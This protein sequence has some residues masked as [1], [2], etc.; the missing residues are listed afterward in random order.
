MREKL[1]R[2]DSAFLL[3]VGERKDFWESSSRES[4]GGKEDCEFFVLFFKER[5]FGS[6]M[7][8]MDRRGDVTYSGE[9]RDVRKMF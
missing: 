9:R 5:D 4:W 3:H 7:A 1:A 2:T 6:F 8:R